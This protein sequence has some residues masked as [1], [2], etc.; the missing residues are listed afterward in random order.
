[1][2]D[3]D[4]ILEFRLE[5]TGGVEIICQKGLLVSRKQEQE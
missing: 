4:D 2:A 3:G 5:Y 1:M